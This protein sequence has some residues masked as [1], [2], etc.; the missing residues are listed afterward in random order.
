MFLLNLGSVFV[1]FF[2]E[3]FFEGKGALG[4]ERV[5]LFG[6][7]LGFNSD[8]FFFDWKNG[9]AGVLNDFDFFDEIVKFAISPL[10]RSTLGLW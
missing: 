7:F 4:S 8:D 9:L 1:I 2:F 6:D 5:H 3:H 10:L